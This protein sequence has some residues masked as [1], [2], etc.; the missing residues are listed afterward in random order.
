MP[1]PRTLLSAELGDIDFKII[2]GKW[3]DDICG[4]IYLSAPRHEPELTYV[5]FGVGHMNRLSLRPGM[6]GAPSDRFAWRS[7]EV[8][9]PSARLKRLRPAAFRKKLGLPGPLG[10]GNWANTSPL[11]WGDRLFATWD[12]GRP[13]ELDPLSLDFLGE[14]GHRDSW[15]GSFPGRAVLPFIFTTAHPV[16]DPERDCMWSVKLALAPSGRGLIPHLVR[17]EGTGTDVEVWP[18]AGVRFGGTVH[19]ISQ[20]K[21]WLILAESGNFKPDPGEMMGGQRSVKMDTRSP[22]WLIRKDMVDDLP[23]GTS[24]P[25][26]E[27]MIA[28]PVGHY[29]ALYESGDRLRVLFEHMDFLDLG[30]YLRAD[31]IDASGR[32]VDRSQVGGSNMAMGSSTISEIEIDARTGRVTDIARVS[33]DWMFNQQLG[34]MDASIVGRTAPT[35]HHMVYQG[36]RPGNVSQ[37]VLEHYADRVRPRDLPRQ[38]TPP[39]LATFDRGELRCMSR[40]ALSLDDLPSSPTF[41]PRMRKAGARPGGHDGYIVLPVHCDRGARIEVFDA[42]DVAAGPVATLVGENRQNIPILQHTAWIP[43]AK[44]APSMER[45]LFSHE[46]DR[47]LIESLD[48]DLRSAVLEVV[49]QLEPS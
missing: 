38:E 18:L 13:V 44:P 26:T 27:A 16:I 10:P 8:A 12:M 28:P 21:D 30:F 39:F 46:L 35:R 1:V 48:G 6:Y 42:D 32:P 47:A 4:E 24:V 22:V 3:P 17:Y 23:A 29:H 41:V 31:D 36:Y 5:A 2:G 20:S 45:L 15:G 19:A 40:Y 33:E 14:V 34:A 9:T 25:M 37:R 49:H 7:A 11:F 43:V